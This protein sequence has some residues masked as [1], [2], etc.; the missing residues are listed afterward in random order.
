[1]LGRL[2]EMLFVPPLCPVC[3][4]R[5]DE[6]EPV[7]SGCLRRLM[8]EPPVHVRPPP[9]IVRVGSAFSHEGPARVLLNTFKFRSGASLAPLVA[10]LIM[11][12]CGP[13]I[14]GSGTLV[15]VPPSVA[16]LSSR[17]FDTAALVARE[18]ARLRPESE[19]GIAT[20]SRPRVSRQLGRTRAERLEKAGGIIAEVELEGRVMLVDDVLTTGSTLAASARAARL[21]G[22][23]EV[24]AVTFSRR[25]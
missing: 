25:P 20:L 19:P 11:D 21:A 2:V 24:E 9:G 5:A 1:M 10:S 3:G 16:G 13:L 6:G 17:G 23:T 22:A 15:P 4:M 7:C 12:R 18:L 14:L 8:A